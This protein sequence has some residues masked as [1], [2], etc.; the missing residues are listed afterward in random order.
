MN[1]F[2][3]LIFSSLLLSNVGNSLT[4]NMNT[5]KHLSKL[6]KRIDARIYKLTKPAVLN[7]VIVPV[8]GLVDSVWVSRLGNSNMLAGQGCGDQVF[9]MVYYIFS[10]LPAVLAPEISKLYTQDKKEDIKELVNISIIISMLV[11]T[12]LSLSIF[13]FSDKVVNIFIGDKANIRSY[14]IEYL[15]FRTMSFPFVFTN[16]VVFSILRGMTDFN[17]AIIIN[18]QSQIINIIIDPILMKK[19]GLKGVAIGSNIADIYCT[20]RYLILFKDKKLYSKTI[21]NILVKG[22]ELLSKG[23][24]VQIKNICN[25]LVYLFINNKVIQLDKDGSQTAAHILSAKLYDLGRVL[26]DGLSS[27][28]SIIIPSEKIFDNDLIAKKRLLHWSNIFGLSQFFL[29]LVLSLNVSLL[30]N[31]LNVIA[32]VKKLLI[33]I[34]V[35]QYFSGLTSTNEGILQ[36][37]QKYKTQSLLAVMSLIIMVTLTSL[38]KSVEQIWMTGIIISIIKLLFF[39][40]I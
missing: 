37:Y 33:I 19:Y 40:F 25:N 35:L 14:A 38:S 2:N 3:L 20:V 18:L 31:D 9:S 26:F 16:S 36:G 29:Y 6:D 34:S 30:T 15:K 39:R 7:H 23:I 32:Q 27:V 1:F 21:P 10:F 11:G 12:F 22:R 8:V 4:L 5:P 24:F 28:S 17:N 13:N